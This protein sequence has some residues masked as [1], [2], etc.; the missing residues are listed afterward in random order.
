L[1]PTNLWEIVWAMCTRCVPVEDI[2]FIRKTRS[3]RWTQHSERHGDQLARRH[4][5]GRST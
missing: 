4:H 5:G 1:D 2:D 3:G